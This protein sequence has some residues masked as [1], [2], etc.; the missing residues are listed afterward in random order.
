MNLLLV[1]PWDQEYGGVASVVGNLARQLHKKGHQTFFLHPGDTDILETRTTKW[2][3]PGY[4]LNLR[5]PFIPDVPVKSIVAFF[6][7]LFPTLRQLSRLLVEQKINIVNIHYPGESG[8]YFALLRKFCRFKLVVSIHGADLFPNGKPKS[9]YSRSIQ[10]L[11]N[12][13]DLIITPSQNT[14][15]A[16]ITVFPHLQSKGMFIHNGINLDEFV[17]ESF[18]PYSGKEYI[19][20]VATHEYKKGID[21]LIQAL[22]RLNSSKAGLE[23]WLV[24]EG[25][26]HGEL[27]QLVRDLDL[28]TRVK[29]LGSR[30]RAEI[31]KLMHQCTLFVLPSRAEPFGIVLLEAL[32]CRKPVIATAVGGIPE[33]IEHG[34]NGILV[35]PENPE[36][37][38]TAI[39][40]V[41]QDKELQEI[42]GWNGYETVKHRFQWETAA[43]RYVSVFQGLLG[44]KEES[45][46]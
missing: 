2:H 39:E 36:V 5:D 12:T 14:L 24:G 4:R 35:E 28:K 6:Y 10:F 29:F 8:I 32:A 22:A 1:V 37:L 40:T 3:F 21:V 7:Y 9:H 45:F 38:S 31:W 13:A 33:I 11:L 44:T 30:N 17:P 26:L 23:L 41:L 46:Q 16:V 18:L 27:E 43:T 42:M 25:P 34:K 20:C 19:L 15:K